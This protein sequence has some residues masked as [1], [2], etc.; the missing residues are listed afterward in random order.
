MKIP[1]QKNAMMTSVFD[2]SIYRYFVSSED[3]DVEYFRPIG[4]VHEEC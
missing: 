1:L 2:V 3:V 4:K